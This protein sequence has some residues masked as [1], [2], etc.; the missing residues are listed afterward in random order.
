MARLAG[1]TV[2]YQLG[3]FRVGEVQSCAAGKVVQVFVER[4]TGRP[5][6]LPTELQVALQRLCAVPAS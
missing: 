2:E 4:A 1:S 5:V 6:V 3:L